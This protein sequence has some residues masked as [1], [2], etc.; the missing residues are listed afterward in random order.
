MHQN[1]FFYEINNAEFSWA[2]FYE[3][4]W[5]FLLFLDIDKKVYG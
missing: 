1:I 5:V 4:I 2:K 3:F